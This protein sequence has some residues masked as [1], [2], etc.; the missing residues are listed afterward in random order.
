MKRVLA[1]LVGLVLALVGSV[2]VAAWLSSGTGI[3]SATA[4]T[5]DQAHAPVATRVAGTVSLDW[6]PSTLANGAPVT[7]YDVFR[8]DGATSTLVCTATS[9]SCV[10]TA[11]ISTEV[12]YGVVAR[13]GTS[14]RGPES[15]LTL[16]TYDD[17]APVTTA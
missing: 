3:A 8:H 17:V 4:T 10:D 13:I 14:W 1:V 11:P 16:L 7:A 5:V 12:G 2:A 15:D 6:D 9:T